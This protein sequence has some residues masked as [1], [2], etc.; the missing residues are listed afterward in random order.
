MAD[1][2]SVFGNGFLAYHIEV[3]VNK[4]RVASVKAAV[5]AWEP[6]FRAQGSW[7]GFPNSMAQRILQ[8]PGV[9]DVEIEGPQSSVLIPLRMVHGITG[10]E[11]KMSTVL[12]T[13][14]VTQAIEQNLASWGIGLETIRRLDDVDAPIEYSF[15]DPDG[16]HASL[17]IY[18]ASRRRFQGAIDRQET[19]CEHLVLNR[20]N[21]GLSGLAERVANSGGLV[22]F[23][24]RELGRHD[25]VEDFISLLQYTNHL[26]LSGRH[27]VMKAFARHAG[28]ETSRGWP[29]D[30]ASLRDQSFDQ[31]AAWLRVRMRPDSIVVLHRNERAD[32]AFYR[33]TV[34][35]VIVM[36][37]EGYGK[38][39]R[40]ARI[41]G[42]LFGC[43]MLGDCCVSRSVQSADWQLCC[44]HV[45]DL[46][47][48]GT[49]ERP[50]R[51]PK[52]TVG[53]SVATNGRQVGSST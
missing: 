2:V 14:P 29:D 38:E 39:S 43:A 6:T 42:A 5:K 18:P 9:I 53:D 27:G 26:V 20:F 34:E 16:V 44:E 46:A 37:P 24:P 25:R 36:A 8:I 13:G 3:R 12:G 1:T 48:T 19:P 11:C 21:A 33:G 17:T 31:L 10:C 7:P 47:F 32:T 51:Y 35:P 23:R 52:F 41:Q 15:R 40:A 30:R 4:E 22:S 50:W 28:I 45:V 49:D